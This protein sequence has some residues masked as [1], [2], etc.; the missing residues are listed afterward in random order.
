MSTFASFDTRGSGILHLIDQI[1]LL[2]TPNN[3]F[4]FTFCLPFR[5][6]SLTRLSKNPLFEKP[7]EKP[8]T[9]GSKIAKM[10]PKCGAEDPKPD[11]FQCFSPTFQKL[12]LK[13]DFFDSFNG[14]RYWRWGEDALDRQKK[15]EVRKMPEKPHR[16]HPSSARFVGQLCA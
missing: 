13:R 8:P 14:S 10:L 12:F 9:T 11:A 4:S 15:L 6:N 3:D 7:H 16:T 5:R 2:M 1:L